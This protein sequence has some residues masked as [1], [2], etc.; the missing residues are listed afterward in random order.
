MISK[1]YLKAA[2]AILDK[3]AKGF[4]SVVRIEPHRIVASSGIAL[5]VIATEAAQCD[6]TFHISAEYLTE[7]FKSA[8][9]SEFGSLAF[10]KADVWYP[11]YR[12]VL[13]QHASGVP[14][15]FQTEYLVRFA[16]AAK[17]LTGSPHFGIA[18]NGTEPA[19]ISFPLP[20]VAGIL[21]PLQMPEVRQVSP[22]WA[23][24]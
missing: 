24:E 18:H 16:K 4:K 23:F 13:R 2:L 17:I 11:D 22:D 1:N 3:N 14:S 21:Q 6:E 15:Q 5:L 20:Y 10:P 12:P 8:T 19:I 9:A 7:F